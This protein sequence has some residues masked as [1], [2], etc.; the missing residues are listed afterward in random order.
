MQQVSG[1]FETVPVVLVL[2]AVGRR[3]PCRRHEA[4]HATFYPFLAGGPPY[5]AQ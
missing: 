3:L 1:E 5:S 4:L 2:V